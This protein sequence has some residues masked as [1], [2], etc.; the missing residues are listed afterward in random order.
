MY[1]SM[2]LCTCIAICKLSA[3]HTPRPS[4]AAPY[5]P[6]QPRLCGGHSVPTKQLA[7]PTWA[8][9][10][11]PEIR[12]PGSEHTGKG[13]EEVHTTC[14]A[15]AQ[16]V[17]FW[18]LSRKWIDHEP[19]YLKSV[20]GQ[21]WAVVRQKW[22]HRAIPPSQLKATVQKHC[23]KKGKGADLSCGST[24]V[25]TQ[26]HPTCATQSHCSR[27]LKNRLEPDTYQA[28]MCVLPPAAVCIYLKCIHGTCIYIYI[29]RERER[30][31]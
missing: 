15:C 26:S 24:E 20:R 1:V 8:V 22:T 13:K 25:N 17:R 4:A 19:C 6:W 29:Y 3:L 21:T 11:D 5:S 14:I 27:A 2:H 12:D 16:Q 31:T 10:H 30:Y 23:K 18:S 28:G 7:T 9:V